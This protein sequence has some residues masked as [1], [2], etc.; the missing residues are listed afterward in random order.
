MTNIFLKR[1]YEAYDESD[2]ARILID[3]L[4][5]RGVSKEKARLTD[6][7]KEVAP[8]PELCKWFSHKPERFEE[9]RDKYLDELRTSD[10]KLGLINQILMMASKG[11]VTLL[12]GS[13]DQVHNQAQVLFAELTR[14]M[15]EN[16]SI[17]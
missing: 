9:F 6:W 17:G 13:K 11:K 12:Y 8:S 3:R 5:P 2:G 7:F 1:V 10:V 4:W 15:E 14:M 16:K